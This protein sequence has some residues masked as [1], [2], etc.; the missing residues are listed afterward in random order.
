MSK[1]LLNDSLFNK[2]KQ[3]YEQSGKQCVFQYN[4]QR[5]LKEYVEMETN[6]AHLKAGGP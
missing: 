6:L 1:I 3:V 5:S 4:T 2:G